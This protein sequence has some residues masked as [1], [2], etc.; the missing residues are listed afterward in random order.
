[1]SLEVVD[2]RG[3]PLVFFIKLCGRFGVVS[4]FKKLNLHL[5]LSGYS[6]RCGVVREMNR[7]LVPG[8]ELETMLIKLDYIEY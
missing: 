3:D 5:A 2:M 8:V 1:M 4:S 6:V 7:V